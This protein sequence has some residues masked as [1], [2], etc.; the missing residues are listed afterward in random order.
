MPFIVFI[1]IIGIILWLISLNFADK[2][3]N[4]AIKHV[5]NPIKDLFK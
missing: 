4:L 3:G 2:I 5:I 1:I